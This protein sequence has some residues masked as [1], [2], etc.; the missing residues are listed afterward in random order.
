MTP[1]AQLRKDKA[2]ANGVGTLQHRHLAAIAGIIV[3]ISPGERGDIA[4]HF[5]NEIAA[6]NPRF[7]RQRF[8]NACEL[9]RE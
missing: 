9:G 7:D 6:G 3:K 8:L 4:H 2:S 1:Q 5:A